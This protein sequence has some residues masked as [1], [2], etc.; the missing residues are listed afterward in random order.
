M[1]V[2]LL[3][4]FFELVG[5]PRLLYTYPTSDT[6]LFITRIGIGDPSAAHNCPAVTKSDPNLAL[7]PN[8]INELAGENLPCSKRSTCT[9]VQ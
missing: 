3:D 6:E 8:A 9:D 5:V 2:E 7:D 1:V 4:G